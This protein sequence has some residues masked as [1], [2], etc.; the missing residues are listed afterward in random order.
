MRRGQSR[1]L[2]GD[3]AQKRVCCCH[4]KC[5]RWLIAAALIGQQICNGNALQQAL[6]GFAWQHRLQWLPKQPPTV[7]WPSYLSD[8]SWTNPSTTSICWLARQISQAIELGSGCKWAH[9]LL[10]HAALPVWS[11]MTA[12]ILRELTCSRAIQP[13]LFIRSNQCARMLRLSC[14]SHLLISSCSRHTTAVKQSAPAGRQCCV[15]ALD[16]VICMY[17]QRQQHKLP[18]VPSTLLKQRSMAVMICNKPF[19]PCG[20]RTGNGRDLTGHHHIWLKALIVVAS[21][22]VHGNSGSRWPTYVL[23]K[24]PYMPGDADPSEA[25]AL[26]VLT[27]PGD[28]R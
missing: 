20:L 19:K 21:A 6:K 27:T 8:L 26:S 16:I 12:A 15:S 5:G 4:N 23:T 24:Q 10:C 22:P 11:C 9:L 17:K 14:W 7:C 13:W 2:H 25:S 18:P 3:Q 1:Q 28:C